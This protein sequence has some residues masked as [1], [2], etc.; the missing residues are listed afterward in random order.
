VNLLRVFERGIAKNLTTG[1]YSALSEMAIKDLCFLPGFSRDSEIRDVS[2]HGLYAV[3]LVIEAQGGRC[4]LDSQIGK[5]AT[6]VATLPRKY[7]FYEK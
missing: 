6:L 2:K 3:R 4:W 7:V 1:P 5:G